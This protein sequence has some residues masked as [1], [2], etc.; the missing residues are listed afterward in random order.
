MDV[1][2]LTIIKEKSTMMTN[3]IHSIELKKRETVG[4]VYYLNNYLNDL[5]NIVKNEVTENDLI[6]LKEVDDFYNSLPQFQLYYSK[7][8]RFEDKLNL[9][10]DI[11]NNIS[12]WDYSYMI[13]LTNG[14]YCGLL[15]ILSLSYFNW[16]FSFEDERYGLII[17]IREDGKEKILLD[18]YEENSIEFIDIKIYKPI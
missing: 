13:Y 14:N 7:T 17:L 6:S 5:N 12:D 16:N 8:L 15:K 18:F 4:K 10:Q 2:D 1:Q 9:Y 3:N 11:K